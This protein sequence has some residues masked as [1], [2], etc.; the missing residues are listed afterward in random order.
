MP[1]REESGGLQSMGLQRAGNDGAT[2][3]TPTITRFIGASLV[4]QW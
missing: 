4:A 1:W 2:K 3:T